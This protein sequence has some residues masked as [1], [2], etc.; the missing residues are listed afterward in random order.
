M[1]KAHAG[2]IWPVFGLLG[3]LVLALVY[4]QALWRR[5]YEPAQPVPF[6]HSTHTAADKANMPCLA[7]H[8]GA[9]TAAGTALPAAS[10]CM[11][12][13]RHILA[14]DARLLPLH[15]AANPD[16]PVYTGEPLRWRRA[17]PLPAHA[18]FHHGVHARKM[19]CERCHPTP[20][21]ESPLR[22][23]DCLSCHRDENL[24]TDCTQCHR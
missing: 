4:L 15:A 9:D 11:D 5:P 21:R 10:T 24:P 22:M 12:C 18:H 23:R 16:S 13:H 1:G 14:Q 6:D 17:Y 8:A 7:C 20:G 3:A 2:R 19:D